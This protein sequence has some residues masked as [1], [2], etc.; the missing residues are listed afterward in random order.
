MKFD[1]PDFVAAETSTGWKPFSFGALIAVA[2]IVVLLLVIRAA[3]YDGWIPILDSANLALHEAGHPLIGIFSTRL[4][5]Y[6][7][8]LI[9]I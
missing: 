7:L 9:H 4:M 6:G 5:V 2:S 1:D 3:S 8:S